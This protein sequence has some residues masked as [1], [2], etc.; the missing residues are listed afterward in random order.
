M[1]GGLDVAHRLPLS[2]GPMI[3]SCATSRLCTFSWVAAVWVPTGGDWEPNQKEEAWKKIEWSAL[4]HN[5]MRCFLWK[6][7]FGV[8]ISSTQKLKCSHYDRP[9]PTITVSAFQ[10]LSRL[11]LEISHTPQ[12]KDSC[13]CCSSFSYVLCTRTAF[14]VWSRLFVA[15]RC[16]PLPLSLHHENVWISQNRFMCTSF[17]RVDARDWPTSS[18]FRFGTRM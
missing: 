13:R 8:Q 17:C 15:G 1:V 2:G 18:S 12:I 16:N 5:Q 4:N 10:S 6:N 11:V 3:C 7:F 14:A 9:F